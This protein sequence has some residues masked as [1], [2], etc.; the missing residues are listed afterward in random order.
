VGWIEDT[1]WPY[2]QGTSTLY[3]KLS[4]LWRFCIRTWGTSAL[5]FQSAAKR[6]GW[7]QRLQTM[8]RWNCRFWGPSKIRKIKKHHRN[9]HRDP[10]SRHCTIPFRDFRMGEFHSSAISAMAFSHSEIVLPVNVHN[11]ASVIRFWSKKTGRHPASPSYIALFSTISDGFNPIR[12][13]TKLGFIHF[14]LVVSTPLKN[15]K[16]S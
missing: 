8:T 15:M 9:C 6:H 12:L 14:W 1:M 4:F 7:F 16:V 11:V 10:P 2:D 5:V 3:V 13:R